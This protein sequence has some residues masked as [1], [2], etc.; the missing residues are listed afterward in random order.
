MPR[1]APAAVLRLTD[2]ACATSSIALRRWTAGGRPVHHLIDPRTGTP[3]DSSVASVTVVGED[4]ADAEV[5]SKTLLLL[6]T[7]ALDE[8]EAR[9]I[10]ALVQHRDG[11]RE[12]ASA[13]RPLLVWEA[14]DGR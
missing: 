7:S 9:G 14:G 3:A 5:W 8:A 12:A 10:A 13:L 6:G 4:P 2:Q 1:G 11:R